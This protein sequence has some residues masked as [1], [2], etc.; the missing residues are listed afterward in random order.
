MKI[1][2]TRDITHARAGMRAHINNME[3][4]NMKRAYGGKTFKT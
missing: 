4:K 2:P 3:L 1:F